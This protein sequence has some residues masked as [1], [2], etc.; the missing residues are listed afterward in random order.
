MAKMEDHFPNLVLG[1][2]DDGNVNSYSKRSTTMTVEQVFAYYT[3]PVW[4][5]PIEDTLLAFSHP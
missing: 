3:E 2:C 4:E 1:F 5:K